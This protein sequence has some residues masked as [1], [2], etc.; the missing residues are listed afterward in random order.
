MTDI[1]KE[2]TF[3]TDSRFRSLNDDLRER[4]GEKLYKLTLNGGCTCPNRD[5]TLGTRGCIFCS[6]GGSGEFAASPQLSIQE[7]IE[8][9][10]RRLAG[11][12]PVKKYIAYFQAYTNTYAPVEHLRRVFTEAIS[13]PEIAVLSIATRP[14]CLG[15]EVL[16]LLEELNRRKPVWVELGLQTIHEKT[17]SFIRRGY[18]LPV[19]DRAVKELEARGI[20][21]IVHTI[22]GLPGE[23]A[24]MMLDTMRYVNST[25]AAGIKLQ[26]LHILKH[27][28]LADYY[29]HTGFHILTM[30]EYV[31]LVI[32]CLEV[33]RPDLV[34]HRLTG[35]GPKD[36]L[37][38][39]EWSQAKRQVLN[40]I[41][42]EL[43]RRNTFQ[44]RLYSP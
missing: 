33:C 4:F 36:L 35:D 24:D 11:K 26:L 38:A 3:L 2:N 23:T 20:E 9:G 32:R 22:L 27:T 14:D 15:E 6:E 44:G 37:I 13:C 16:E 40:T 30:N 31:D 29:Q 19:F 7:Q 28:D 18:P 21:I 10:K 41:Q 25:P 8:D 42:K 34:I 17:A 43:K 39:P 12:R 1:T 5:G